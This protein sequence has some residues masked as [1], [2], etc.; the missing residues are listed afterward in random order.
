MAGNLDNLLSSQIETAENQQQQLDAA[1]QT[2]ITNETNSLTQQATD[3]E[4]LIEL[5]L[6][7]SS[8]VANMVEAADNP[9]QPYTSVF[10][11]L[12]A[13]VGSNGTQSTAPAILSLFA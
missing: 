6:G 5:N 10:Q 13:A 7:S 8:A 12:Q 4:H 3:Q 11:A 9:P 1:D 2:A